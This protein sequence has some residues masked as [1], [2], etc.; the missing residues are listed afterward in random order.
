MSYDR[1]PLSDYCIIFHALCF[2]F[3]LFIFMQVYSVFRLDSS[4]FFF[5]GTERRLK[6]IVDTTCVHAT[7]YASWNCFLGCFNIFVIAVALSRLLSTSSPV[8]FEL[9]FMSNLVPFKQRIFLFAFLDITN[10]FLDAVGVQ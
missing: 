8:S 2:Y 1:D 4:S 7:C 10:C 3:Q 9:A 6:N 5:F